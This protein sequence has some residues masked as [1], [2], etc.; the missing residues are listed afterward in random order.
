M[1]CTSDSRPWAGCSLFLLNIRSDY[2][3]FRSHV[4]IPDSMIRIRIQGDGGTRQPPCT[5]PSTSLA[6]GIHRPKFAAENLD[7]ARPRLKPPP[8]P[9]VSSGPPG[10][11]CVRA[12]AESSASAVADGHPN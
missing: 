10:N 9:P 5:P 8:R 12:E 6:S 7:L 11:T 1:E 3:R 4:E 2:R